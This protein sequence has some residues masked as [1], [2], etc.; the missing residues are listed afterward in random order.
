M[1][2]AV[3]VELRGKVTARILFAQGIAVPH[4]DGKYC[5]GFGTSLLG[6]FPGKLG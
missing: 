5:I 1:T 4:R 2:L 6:S 3:L